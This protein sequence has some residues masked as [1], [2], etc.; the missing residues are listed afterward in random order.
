MGATRTNTAPDDI[1]LAPIWCGRVGSN[2]LH[3]EAAHRPLNSVPAHSMFLLRI[4]FV[5]ANSVGS[6][7]FYQPKD[8]RCKWPS[9]LSGLSLLKGKLRQFNMFEYPRRTFSCALFG[10]SSLDHRFVFKQ[11]PFYLPT[12]WPYLV[13]VSLCAADSKE[14]IQCYSPIRHSRHRRK[15]KGLKHP[16]N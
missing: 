8:G 3:R 1:N 16:I 6:S 10:R 11:K 15:R 14:V 13:I 7:L 2:R 12:N 5:Q 9:K 4:H